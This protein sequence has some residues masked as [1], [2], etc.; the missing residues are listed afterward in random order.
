MIFAACATN[1]LTIG[2]TEPAQITIPSNIDRVGVLNR[3]NTITN[4]LP[5]Q[6]DEIL[7][8]ELLTND[9]TVAFIVLDGIVNELEKNN[10]FVDVINLKPLIL[11]N[12]SLDFFSN[13]LEKIEI[14]KICTENNLKAL[15]VL[16]YF[17][18]DTRA[19]FDAVPVTKVV[20]GRK[21]NAIVTKAEV[22]TIIKL[23]WRIYDAS[24][25]IIYDQLPVVKNVVSYGEGINPL[26]AIRAVTGHKN[27]VQQISYS[28][29]QKYAQDLLPVYH[30]VS[31]IYYVKGTDNFKIGKRLARAG[32]WD[33]AADYWKKDINNSKRKIAG[34][35]HFNMAIINEING[36]IDEA[37]NWSEKSYTIYNNKKALRYLKTLKSRKMNNKILERQKY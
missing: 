10:R 37:I 19:K 5:K 33:E 36:N 9:S 17:D 18:S 13:N 22:N 27:T 25:D 23:G 29:G 28:L 31:R 26:K 16:E 7:S 20:L 3:T 8:L 21:V 30:R 12:S 32:N 6:V 24:G 2:V 11:D 4:V 35:A 14:Q 34:R 1:E 15:F